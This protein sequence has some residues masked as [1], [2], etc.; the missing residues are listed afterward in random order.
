MS[1]VERGP[2]GGTGRPGGAPEKN[3][4]GVEVPALQAE[5]LAK[6]YGAR[7]AVVDAS[8]TLRRGEVFGFLGPNGAGK[9]TTIRMLVGL[10]HPST[11]RV[12]VGGHD[13]KQARE[14]A[15]RQLG[16]IVE[17]PD[18]YDYLTGRENLEHAARMIGRDAMDRI[19]PVTEMLR[20]RERLSGRV[21][22]Y[23]LGMRQ[24]LGIAQA[25]LGDP[26]VLVLDEPANGLDPAGIRELRALL[27]RLAD[28]RGLAVFV[29]SH[30]LGEVEKVCDRIAIV[31]RGRVLAEGS[32]SELTGGGP[33]PAGDRVHGRH[34]RRDRRGL[35][36]LHLRSWLGL[37][38]NETLKMLRRKRPQLV[39]A[40]LTIFLSISVWAQFRQQENSRRNDG[41]SRR[42]QQ[43]RL[44]RQRGKA[45]ARRRAA[46]AAGAASSWPGRACSSSRPRACATTWSATSTPT[47]RPG[48]CSP[49]RSPCWPAPCCCRC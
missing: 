3:G 15:L 30:L 43:H 29:S 47:S 37:C 45:H 40:V 17:S 20:I 13:L 7:Q 21:G 36:E 1:L 39:L 2:G 10:I 28:D 19:E 34:G 23:S 42:D 6:S 5:H 33:D 18:F 38:E 14:A 16:C 44:A 31:H 32:I 24:R 26:A 25:L 27:R 46:R 41:A 35:S 12:V 8:F 48:R 49:A 4:Q 11:G 22:T 9:T